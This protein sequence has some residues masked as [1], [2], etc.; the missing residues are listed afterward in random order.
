MD[1]WTSFFVLHPIGSIGFL[2]LHMICH[3]LYW[4]HTQAFQCHDVLLK[5]QRAK[6]KGSTFKSPQKGFPVGRILVDKII[7]PNWYNIFSI[8]WGGQTIKEIVSHKFN[9][10]QPHIW[11]PPWMTW[12]PSRWIWTYHHWIQLKCDLAETMWY[13]NLSEWACFFGFL[14]A[15]N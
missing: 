11:G 5:H 1:T 15:Y 2:V 14:K 10:L 7:V 9:T 13:L 6:R 4:H 12:R 3:W 8:V